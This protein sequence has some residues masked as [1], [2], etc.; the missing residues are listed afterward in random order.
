MDVYRGRGGTDENFLE[1]GSPPEPS[2]A[3][4]WY[5]AIQHAAS[6]ALGL[7]A[8]RRIIKYYTVHGQN[9]FLF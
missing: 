4:A 6:D 5:W 3:T 1:N 2:S 8:A 9:G 7:C